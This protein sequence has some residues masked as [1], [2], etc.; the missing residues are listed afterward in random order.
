MSERVLLY[1][2]HWVADLRT[3]ALIRPCM[4]WTKWRPAVRSRIVQ[5]SAAMYRLHSSFVSVNKCVGEREQRIPR[6]SF[7]LSSPEFSWST[8]SSCWKQLQVGG[9]Y[10]HRKDVRIVGIDTTT[11]A[12]CDQTDMAG[13][14]S[15]F[16]A[17]N[18]IS[19]VSLCKT[20]QPRST[21]Q[22]NKKQRPVFWNCFYIHTSV[23][24]QWHRRSERSRPSPL[25]SFSGFWFLEKRLK[26]GRIVVRRMPC[27]WVIRPELQKICALL[28][29]A[30]GTGSSN[31]DKESHGAIVLV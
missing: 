6:S 17:A 11:T 18:R 14:I 27:C 26:I 2:R 28:I 8:W 12:P 5:R 7:P 22:H 30:V 1:T 15:S 4:R 19:S 29:G 3:I 21:R 20:K 13:F 23:M 16:T 24:W 31:T 25:I 9:I 10:R